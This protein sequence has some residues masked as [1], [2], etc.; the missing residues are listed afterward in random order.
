MKQENLFPTDEK[1]R[2]YCRNES[3]V[4]KGTMENKKFNIYLTIIMVTLKEM[5]KITRIMY[6]ISILCEIVIIMG[7]V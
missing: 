2:I 4:Q 6:D 7:C 5:S 1:W 3:Q